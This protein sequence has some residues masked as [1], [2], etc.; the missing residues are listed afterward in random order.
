MRASTRVDHHVPAVSALLI[1]SLLVAVILFSGSAC[2]PPPR[3]R[4]EES[5]LVGY[6]VCARDADSPGVEFKADGTGWIGGQD[7]D[8]S[9]PPFQWR[10]TELGQVEVMLLGE[11]GE[12]GDY[13]SIPYKIEGGRLHLDKKIGNRVFECTELSRKR[14]TRS[15]Q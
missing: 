3:L 9:G 15:R 4:G 13:V 8:A 11:E 14:E 1:R 5:K 7:G 6:W 10:V 12:H 2:S